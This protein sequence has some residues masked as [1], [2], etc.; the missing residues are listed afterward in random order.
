MSDDAETSDRRR[1]GLAKMAEVYGW[2][3][4]DGPG[5]FFSMTVEHLFG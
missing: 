2:E 5:E 4:G 1:R 3:V